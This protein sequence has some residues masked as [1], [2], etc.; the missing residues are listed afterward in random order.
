MIKHR[1]RAPGGGRKPKGEFDRLSAAVT[2]RMPVDLRERLVEAA[3]KNDRSITQELLRRLHD[4][5]ARDRSKE[6]EPAMRAL[7]FLIAEIANQVVGHGFDEADK[8]SLLDE[9]KK[10]GFPIYFPDWRSEPFYFR[11]FKL[12]VVQLLDA[13]QPPGD[14][15]PPR[16]HLNLYPKTPEADAFA[17]RFNRSF[18]SPEARADYAA[19]YVLNSIMTVRQQSIEERTAGVRRMERLGLTHFLREQYNM[20]DAA[21]DLQIPKSKSKS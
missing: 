3:D 8:K 14:V 4:S 20:I 15:K 9:S 1:K 13:L 2:T 7:C 11:A 21:R 6:R 5:F 12:A 16:R 17:A 10:K 19:G 18:E